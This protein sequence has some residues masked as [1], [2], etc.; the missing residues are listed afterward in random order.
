MNNLTDQ[1]FW[2]MQKMTVFILSDKMATR[3]VS[4]GNDQKI[5]ASN[6]FWGGPE[7]PSNNVMVLGG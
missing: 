4:M 6:R 7:I 1:K 5:S 3:V 2:K